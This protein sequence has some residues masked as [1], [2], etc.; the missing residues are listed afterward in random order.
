[1]N[2]KADRKSLLRSSIKSETAS[3]EKRF[4]PQALD[5]R[6]EAA[7]DALAG[8]PLGLAGPRLEAS[9]AETDLRA[10]IGAP[11]DG[12]AKAIIRIPIDKA[13]DNPFNARHIYDPETIKSL[14]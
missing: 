4:D 11:T 5:K 1:M 3:V 13:H 2:A 10:E 7:E 8:R 9:R 6:D 14:A 12:N